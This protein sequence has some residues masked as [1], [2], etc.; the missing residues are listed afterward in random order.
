MNKSYL[1]KSSR[2][3]YS[4]TANTVSQQFTEVIERLCRQ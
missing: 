1:K 4:H 3:M 2:Q